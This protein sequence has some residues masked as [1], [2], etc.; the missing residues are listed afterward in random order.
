[1][2]SV[3]YKN[4]NS[5]Y[6]HFLIMSPESHF[7]SFLACI[8]ITVPHILMILGRINRPTWSVTCGDDSHSLFSY[9]LP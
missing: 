3:A 1:M 4:D 6:L 9:Y 7:T 5:A 2:Q 8:S